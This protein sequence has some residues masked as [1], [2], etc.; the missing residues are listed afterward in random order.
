MS[1][2][3]LGLAAQEVWNTLSGS[4]GTTTRVSTPLLKVILLKYGD[5]TFIDGRKILL[6]KR[7]LGAGVYEIGFKW[8][9]LK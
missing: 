2:E 6:K 7:S 3:R 9:V 4:V 5:S 1:R 8:E